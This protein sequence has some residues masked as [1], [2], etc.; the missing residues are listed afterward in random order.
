MKAGF[1]QFGPEFGKKDNNFKKVFSALSSTGLDLIVL[2]E[3]FA[4][5]YQFL[6]EDE[7]AGLAEKIPDGRTTDFLSDL[8]RE[9]GLHIVAGL[10]EVN[11]NRFYNSAVLVGPAGFIGFYRKTHLYAEET[12]YF[13]PGDTGFKVWDTEIGIIGI[14]ICFDWFFPE[15]ARSLAIKGAEIIAHPSNLVLPYCPDAMPVRCLENRVYAVTANRIGVEE[16]RKGQLLKF[17]GRSE[18]VSPDGKIL[19]R[20]P[21]DEEIVMQVNIDPRAADDKKINQYND[22]IK[23]RR[24]DIYRVY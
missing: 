22:I 16:R 21:E 17:I 18:I 8:S 5:G 14:M 7:V 9:N 1:F 4:T 12:R 3:F 10:P 23:D 13:T 24:E 19:T 15:S 2:P 6:S 11:G 20:A